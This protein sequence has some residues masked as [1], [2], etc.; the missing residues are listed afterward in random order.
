MDDFWGIAEAIG[1]QGVEGKVAGTEASM[2]SK[3]M[4]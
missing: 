1:M 3:D 2:A 4:L